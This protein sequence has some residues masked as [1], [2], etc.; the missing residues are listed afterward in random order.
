MLFLSTLTDKRN[1]E[2]D[3]LPEVDQNTKKSLRSRAP[4]AKAKWNA[5]KSLLGCARQSRDK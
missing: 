2:D 1:V 4:A 3:E 5:H